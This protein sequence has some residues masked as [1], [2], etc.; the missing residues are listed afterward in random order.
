MTHGTIVQIGRIV[1][2][3]TLNSSEKNFHFIFNRDIHNN[4]L[5]IP[6]IYLYEE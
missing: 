5:Q 3:I 6:N 4:N 1:L 2:K